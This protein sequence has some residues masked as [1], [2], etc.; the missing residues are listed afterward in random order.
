[1]LVDDKSIPDD[2]NISAGSIIKNLSVCPI[3][4]SS[5]V[6]SDPES[7]EIVCSKCGIV[8]SDKIQEN[9]ELPTFFNTEQANFPINKLH[10]IIIAVNFNIASSLF[11]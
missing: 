4:K 8:I 2:N 9:K 7:G 3:C 1:M 10:D 5:S 11:G 6:I